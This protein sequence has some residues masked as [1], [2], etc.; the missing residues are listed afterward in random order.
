VRSRAVIFGSALGLLG[1]TAGGG[2][3]AAL[4]VPAATNSGVTG[5]PLQRTAPVASW[6]GSTSGNWSGYAGGVSGAKLTEASATWKVPSVKKIKGFSST[7]VGIDGDTNSDLIQTGTEQ[8]YTGSTLIYRAWWEILPAAETIIPS[9]TIH[10]GDTMSGSVKDTSGN[11]WVITLK[12]VTTGKSFSIKKTYTGPGA[13]AEWIQE[14]PTNGGVLTLAHY[15]KVT[16]SKVT[17]GVNFASPVNP[18]LPYPQTAIAMTKGNTKQI[19]S[20]PSKPSAAGNAFAVAYGDVQ[21]AAP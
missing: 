5:A 3:P 1:L 7:W 11:N 9:L 15:S 10:P 14:A 2:I 13:S 6:P 17:I 19:I 18:H 12:D 16:F 4:A 20:I 8:D 21:P